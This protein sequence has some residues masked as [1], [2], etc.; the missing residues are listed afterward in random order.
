MKLWQKDKTVQKKIEQFT[1]GKDNELDLQLATFDIIGSLAHIKML[2]S[3][4]LLTENELAELTDALKNLYEIAEEGKLRIEDGVEDIHSQVELMLTKKLGDV[5]KKIHAGRSR[6]DQVL[7]DL[8]LFF[9]NELQ[10]LVLKL[11]ELGHLFIEKSEKHKDTLMPGYTHMQIAMPSSFGLWFGSYAEALS[12]DLKVLR[13][14]FDMVNQNPLGS[15]AGYGSSFPLNR[16]MTTTLLGFDALCYN[17]VNAQMGRGKTELVVAQGLASVALTINKFASDVCLYIGQNHG[18][19]KLPDA[20]TTGSSIMPHKKNPDV[21]EL[22][23]SRTNKL[24]ALQGEIAMMV[25]NLSSGYHRDFQLLKESLFQALSDMHTILDILMFTIPQI[26]INAGIVEDEKY[27]FLFTVEKVNDLVLQGVPF[28]D[29]YK[30]IGSEVESGQFSYESEITH[31]HEGSIGNLCNDEI[32]A[33]MDLT[34]SSFPFEKIQ[35]S[36]LALLQ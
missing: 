9:R 34:V 5:G 35:S 17:V 24:I 19:I 16:T 28:R 25:S 36:I 32:K 4:D 13:G 12:D 3:I 23:R 18:F 15:A 11:Q 1:I 29:A 31:T 21:F 26:K 7:L 2:T 30:Q 8:R 6:N 22:I 27:K 33:K 14:V 10:N 20:L